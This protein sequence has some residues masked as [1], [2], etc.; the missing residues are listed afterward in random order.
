MLPYLIK[1]LLQKILH[2]VP[3]L[4][5]H[6]W[7]TLVE[8]LVLGEIAE[9]AYSIL[10]T[11]L[12]FDEVWKP[13]VDM[14]EQM[15]EGRSMPP[16]QHGHL[17]L[18]VDNEPSID[19]MAHELVDALTS[20]QG[21]YERFP[22]AHDYQIEMSNLRHAFGHLHRIRR[23]IDYMPHLATELDALI[24]GFP[25]PSPEQ[26]RELL[27]LE[28]DIDETFRRVDQTLREDIKAVYSSDRRSTLR[29]AGGFV[30]SAVIAVALTVGLFS[31]LNHVK[32][33]R[34]LHPVSSTRY[35]TH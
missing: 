29:F 17:Q 7:D 16:R 8:V 10:C 13:Y 6:R 2:N 20:V 21:Y 11:N 1:D 30:A 23:S 35:K 14:F 3:I 19:H 31:Y 27:F 25:F 22:D 9:D 28:V 18:V 24:G 34:E 5:D 26:S 33:E 15:S 12:N 32:H 4:R